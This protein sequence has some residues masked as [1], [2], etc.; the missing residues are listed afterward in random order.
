ME[1][2]IAEDFARLYEEYLPRILN[3]MRLRVDEEALA[4]DLTALTFERALAAWGGLRSRAAFAGW[5]FR[6]AH[7]TVAEYYRGRRPMATLDSLAGVQSDDVP[8]ERRMERAEEL[9]ALQ[10]ALRALP[11][12]ER[13]II[14]LKFIGGLGNQEIGRVMGLRAGH[15]AVL[16]YRTLRKVRAELEK[17]RGDER[18]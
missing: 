13:E 10:G 1:R 4:E 8:P 6:I 12:R 18:G 2:P 16:L 17:G 3:Y 5:L 9:V 15:V 14:I 7:N 11:E